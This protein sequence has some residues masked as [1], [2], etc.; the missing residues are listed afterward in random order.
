LDGLAVPEKYLGS[1]ASRGAILNR[2]LT[3]WSIMGR[4]HDF[5]RMSVDLKRK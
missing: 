4:F 5:F 3:Y 1:V 2:A